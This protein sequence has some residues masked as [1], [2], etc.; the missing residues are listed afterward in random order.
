MRERGVGVNRTQE[1]QAPRQLACRRVRQRVRQ[2]LG[3]GRLQL[4]V[5]A[6]VVVEPVQELD[7]AT[8][9]LRQRR[10]FR[11]VAGWKREDLRDV[12]ADH[13][14]GR[15]ATH[16]WGDE[17]AGVVAVRAVA[18]IAESVHQGGPGARGAVAVPAS[19]CRRAGE[20]VARQRRND[21]V[22]GVPWIAAV[23]ARIA[24]RADDVEVLHDRGRPAV[25]KDQRRRI[26]LGGADV[27]EM[28][29]LSVDRRRELGVGVQ[30]RFPGAP[31]VAVAPAVDQ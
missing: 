11:R 4:G 6:Q 16:L 31:V 21:Q 8:V 23:G 22:E 30:P 14:I 7:F 19:L 29:R 24:E 26:R 27:Q 1:L 10:Q 2:R 17:R 12:Y 15:D 5:R 25:R 18:V 20:A 3:R 28:D 13:V 9:C